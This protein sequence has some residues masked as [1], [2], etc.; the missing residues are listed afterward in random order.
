MME[1]ME[2]GRQPVVWGTFSC[3]ASACSLLHHRAHVRHK[4]QALAHNLD[5]VCMT[6]SVHEPALHGS[7]AFSSSHIPEIHCNVRWFWA[8]QVQGGGNCG[9]ALTAA[10]R[11]GLSPVLVTK[12]D[13]SGWREV[14]VTCVIDERKT[15][16]VLGAT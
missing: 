3:S 15:L 16:S 11:L 2:V 6:V 14:A 5:C 1:C 13:L 4:P 10:S 8:V 9:N 7:R 12:V